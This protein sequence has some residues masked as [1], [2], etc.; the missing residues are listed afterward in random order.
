MLCSSRIARAADSR[1]IAVASSCNACA[2]VTDG[3]TRLGDLTLPPQEPPE[4]S[5]LPGGQ[6]RDLVGQRGLADGGAQSLVSMRFPFLG[7]R[8]AIVWARSR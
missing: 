1:R 3:F 2:G 5:A 7:P 4:Q 6:Q 8:P